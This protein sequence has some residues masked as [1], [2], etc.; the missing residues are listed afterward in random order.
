MI[1]ESTG[2]TSKEV[3]TRRDKNKIKI[4]STCCAR[5]QDT[6][7]RGDGS[8]SKQPTTLVR[9]LNLE[10][11]KV[12]GYQNQTPSDVRFSILTVLKGCQCLYTFRCAFL[13]FL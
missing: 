13:V 2:E 7:R 4:I 5:L 10:H 1:Y 8:I 11:V 9:Y 3:S 6:L 12:S